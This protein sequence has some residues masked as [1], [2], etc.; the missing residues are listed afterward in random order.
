MVRVKILTL[1]LDMKEHMHKDASSEA[2]L[3]N[4]NANYFAVTRRI[5]FSE[6]G[7]F[8]PIFELC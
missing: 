8:S 4:D 1:F 3:Y 6:E 7:S 2:P 5:V